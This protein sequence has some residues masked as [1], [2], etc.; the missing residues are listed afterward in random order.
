[1]LSLGA[2]AAVYS[3]VPTQ[4]ISSSV[5]VLTA[6][7]TGASLPADPRHPN[8]LTNPLL[9]FDGGLSFSATILMGSGGSA[10][11]MLSITGLANTAANRR[12][13]FG[14]RGRRRAGR[15][16]FEGS[17]GSRSGSHS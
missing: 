4:Y 16:H 5:I 2:A 7:I 14:V 1:M 10:A 8:P 15:Q 12:L 3:S 17:R 9:N 13:T 11:L 6:P